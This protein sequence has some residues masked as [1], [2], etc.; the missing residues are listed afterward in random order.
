MEGFVGGIIVDL[1]SNIIWEVAGKALNLKWSGGQSDEL[2]AIVGNALKTCDAKLLDSGVFREPL[3]NS[4]FSAI[5][6]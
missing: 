5:S 4:R 3:I 2:S 6:W 1:V